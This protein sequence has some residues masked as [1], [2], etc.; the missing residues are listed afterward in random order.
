LSSVRQP[1]DRLPAIYHLT[2][3]LQAAVEKSGQRGGAPSRSPP[4]FGRGPRVAQNSK[5]H[6]GDGLTGRKAGLQ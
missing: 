2:T 5:V 4:D 6:M 3:A 1:A